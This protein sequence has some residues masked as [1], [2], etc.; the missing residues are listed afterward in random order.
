MEEATPERVALAAEELRRRGNI[1][2]AYTYNEPM[3]GWEFVRDCAKL[4]RERGMKNVVVTNGSVTLETLDEVLPLTDAWNIDLK[5]FTKEGYRR[6]GGDLE[7]VKAFI[8]RCAPLSHVE[9]T[10]LVVPGLNDG[11]EEIE[12]L[13]RWIASI[14]KKIPLHLTRF[15]PRRLMS[16]AAPTDLSLLRSLAIVARKHLDDVTLGNI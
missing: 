10:T 15:F 13:A 12:A 2:A 5:C 4:I 14:D 7:T 8:G 9:L 16:G 1:G 6:L 11:A 3:I